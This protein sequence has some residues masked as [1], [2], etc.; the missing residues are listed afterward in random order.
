MISPSNQLVAGQLIGDA[1]LSL[2]QS[3]ALPQ[4]QPQPVQRLN[5]NDDN[6]G[7][8]I[9]RCN[10]VLDRDLPD[11]NTYCPETG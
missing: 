6:V 10:F 8:L 4:P 2:S 1:E 3:P 11:P 9:D 7:E 5:D